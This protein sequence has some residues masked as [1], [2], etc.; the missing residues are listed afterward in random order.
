MQKELYESSIKQNVEK[1]RKKW[2]RRKKSNWHT[3]VGTNKTGIYTLVLL[4]QA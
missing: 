4:D 2:R 3:V 1:E